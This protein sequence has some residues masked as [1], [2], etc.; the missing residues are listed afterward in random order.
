MGAFVIGRL[1]LRWVALKRGQLVRTF[2]GELCLEE[3]PRRCHH[4]AGFEL[5]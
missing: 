5:L 4:R 2:G 3:S 1:F